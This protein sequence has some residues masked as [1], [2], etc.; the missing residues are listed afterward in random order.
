MKRSE[1]TQSCPTFCDP[2]DSS[3]QAPPS[4]GFSRQ[5]YWSGLLFPSPGDLP[6]PG[7]E[8]PSPALE[9]RFFTPEKL[10]K[11]KWAYYDPE[12]IKN[13]QTPETNDKSTINVCRCLCGHEERRGRITAH[14]EGELS[15]SQGY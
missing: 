2:M 11:L 9:G 12:K 3:L 1:V 14:H 10:G 13:H 8:L 5:E 4:M 7:I 6:N 15:G